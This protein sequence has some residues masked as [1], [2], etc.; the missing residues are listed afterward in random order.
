M[1]LLGAESFDLYGTSLAAITLRG[2][3]IS[4][5]GGTLGLHSSDGTA[6]TGTG[7]MGFASSGF[8][9]IFIKRF[10]DAGVDVIGQGVGFYL[11]DATIPFDTHRNHGAGFGSGTNILGLKWCLNTSFGISVYEGNTVVGSSAPNLIT[12]GTYYWIEAK[13]TN[14]THGGGPNTSTFEVRVNGVPV[15]TVVGRSYIGQ[16]TGIALGSEDANTGGGPTYQC[17]M[18]DWIWWDN[19]TTDHNDFLGERRCVTEYPDADT[20]F[21]DWLPSTGTVGY[22][23]ID[24]APPNDAD[25]ITAPLAGNI[26]EF[27]MQPIGIATTDIAGIVVIARVWKTDAGACEVRLGVHS[28]LFVE[29]SPTKLP[30]TTPAYFSEVFERNPDGDIP[31]TKTAVDNATVR[32]TRDV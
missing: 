16:F 12:A 10:L 4:A 25:Y 22:Q 3:S 19:S 13:A 18:D 24:E 29:N 11:I 23:M 21:A 30:N 7:C 26:S 1:A 14:D 31:W 2:Y 6:R 17:F 20:G 8:S 32:L 15:V 28:G 5:P 9:N 27:G